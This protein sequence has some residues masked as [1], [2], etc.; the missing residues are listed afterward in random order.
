MSVSTS[1]SLYT[2]TSTAS[3]RC[4]DS[5]SQIAGFP[6]I[7]DLDI[8]E[9]LVEVPEHLADARRVLER[10]SL[11]LEQRVQRRVPSHVGVEYVQERVDIS[12]VAPPRVRARRIPRSPATSASATAPRLRGPRTFD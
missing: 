3:G 8:A 1:A 6:G 10:R 11:P 12:A 5:V 7:L 4:Y 2:A 9:R